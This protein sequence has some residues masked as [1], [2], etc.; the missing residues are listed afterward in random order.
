MSAV[1]EKIDQFAIPVCNVFKAKLLNDQVCYQVDLNK[2]SH[3]NNIERELEFGFSFMMDFNEDRQVTIDESFT[4]PNPN[5]NE[6]TMS[7]Y[8][9]KLV[10]DSNQHSIHFNTIGRM[11]LGILHLTIYFLNSSFTC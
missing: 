7:R 11:A 9:L 8:I 5:A 3:R 2:F 6:F 1:G 4:L 10:T